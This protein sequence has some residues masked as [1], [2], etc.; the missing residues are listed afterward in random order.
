MTV[1][2]T[3]ASYFHKKIVSLSQGLF[4]DEIDPKTVK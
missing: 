4:N 3:W 1:S 2:N